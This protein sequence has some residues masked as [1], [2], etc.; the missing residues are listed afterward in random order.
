MTLKALILVLTILF[1]IEK[2]ALSQTTGNSTPEIRPG[3]TEE[4]K[5]QIT[6]VQEEENNSLG[7]I[8]SA[9]KLEE[10]KL[11]IEE[12]KYI[13]A[14]NILKDLKEWLTSATEFHYT[15]YKI[16]NNQQ[17]KATEAK[18]EK[19]HALD[20]GKLRDESYYRLAR[21]YILQN[22]SKDAIPLLVEIIKSQAGQTLGEQAYQAL[23]GIKFSDKIPK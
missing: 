5:P 13:E 21:T 1:C 23:Q 2:H 15:L 6:S 11:L 17:V 20:F 8:Y 16:L 19:A 14:E 7:L 12:K 10:A 22:K 18:I 3:P 9:K 4:L